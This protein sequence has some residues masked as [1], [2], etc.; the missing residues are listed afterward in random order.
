M[1][2]LF[3]I[4]VIVLMTTITIC[5]NAQTTSTIFV[6][7]FDGATIDGSLWRI[8]TW[9]GNGDG[10][11]VGRTQFRCSQ[12]AALPLVSNSTTAINAESFN[13]TG[14]SFYGTDL[15]SKRQFSV[16]KGLI[17]TIR[18]KINAPVDGGIV[19]GIFL[20]DLTTGTN[21]DEIDFEMVTNNP[22]QIHTNIYA[23][24][25]LGAG[26]PDST[27]FQNSSITEYHTY[28]IEWLPSKVSWLVDG[29]IIRTNIDRIPA[30]PMRFHFNMWVPAK[31]W[32]SA[33][34]E[35]LQPT[36]SRD[37]NKIYSMIVDFIRIDSLI[38]PVSTPL[39]ENKK[40]EFNFYPNPATN[41]IYLDLPKKTTINIYSMTGKLL[42]SK[43][44]IA[45]GSISI[46]D[47]SPGVY[48][49][50]SQHD[51]ILNSQKLIVN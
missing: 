27:Y 35:K 11:Y 12:N 33:Y 51:N 47:L 42:I 36:R 15:I 30:G 45:K 34:N 13:P 46:S 19:G 21:H 14:F 18:A 25:Q 23:N 31:E 20:Y 16:G 2:K 1:K 40:D 6:D 39:I 43:K 4:F 24:E 9:L 49:V 26:H 44:D 7:H 29:N 32:Q 3:N 50:V 48:F 10:T 17:I 22:N 41:L 37:S 38:S 5:A 8:P 28:V